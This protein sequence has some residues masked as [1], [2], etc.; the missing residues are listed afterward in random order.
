MA[1]PSGNALEIDCARR[2]PRGRVTHLGGRGPDGRR[3]VQEL[4]QLVSAAER[5]EA[6]YFVVRGAQQIGLRAQDGELVAMVDMGWTVSSLPTC[7]D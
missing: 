7:P 1:N 5:G 4:T 3:W 6:R 2:D